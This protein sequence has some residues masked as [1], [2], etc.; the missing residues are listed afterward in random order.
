MTPNS[1][2]SET[3]EHHREASSFFHHSLSALPLLSY[4]PFVPS[5]NKF[6]LR[7]QYFS[8]LLTEV[9]PQNE[10]FGWK[11][12]DGREDQT[13][14]DF[15]NPSHSFF[16]SRLAGFSEEC[17]V[18]SQSRTLNFYLKLV[19]LFS[20]RFIQWIPLYLLYYTSFFQIIF[21]LCF[22]ANSSPHPHFL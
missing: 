15:P 13:T 1:L 6:L 21:S 20:L 8:T 14:R 17:S 5:S 9:L 22:D 10:M 11:Q 16:V 7:Y 18:S 12:N 19:L 3:M 4:L 2:L